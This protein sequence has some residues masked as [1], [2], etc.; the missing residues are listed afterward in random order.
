LHCRSAHVR[1]A[2]KRSCT[3]L[4][5]RSHAKVPAPGVRSTVFG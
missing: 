3:A 5:A 1:I 2:L 4:A